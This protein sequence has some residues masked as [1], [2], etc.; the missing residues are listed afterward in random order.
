MKAFLWCAVLIL[1]A[2]TAVSGLAFMRG[3]IE[4]FPTEEQI[5]KVRLVYGVI[6]AVSAFLLL[7]VLGRLRA[8]SKG[9]QVRER[10]P[11]NALQAT[12]EDA[13]A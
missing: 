6:F 11:N 7:V 10:L 13:R 4:L 2:L 8:A 1:V 5:G 9:R 3:S 12:R